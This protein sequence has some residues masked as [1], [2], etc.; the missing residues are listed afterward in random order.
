MLNLS[1]QENRSGKKVNESGGHALMIILL[2]RQIELYIL[3]I[4]TLICNLAE[5]VAPMRW[6]EQ[7]KIHQDVTGIYIF[8][9]GNN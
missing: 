9:I 7:I 5:R 4:K 3:S 6:R 1:Q 2:S 8:Y